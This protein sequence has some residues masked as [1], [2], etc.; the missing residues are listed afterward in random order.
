M[1]GRIVPELQQ[2]GPELLWWI[3]G[4]VCRHRIGA[5]KVAN[6]KFL[7]DWIERRHCTKTS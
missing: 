3:L 7:G 4:S 5:E 1:V 2:S 6:R